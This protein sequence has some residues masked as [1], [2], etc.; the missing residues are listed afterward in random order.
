MKKFALTLMMT[1]CASTPQGTDKPTTS[2]QTLRYEVAGVSVVHIA[3]HS[4]PTVKMT[5]QFAEGADS[6]APAEH[7][8]SSLLASLM[9]RGAAG[10]TAM[11]SAEAVDRLG[12]SIAG[13]ASR[14]SMRFSV[15]GLSRDTT[16]LSAMLA[17]TVRQPNL[18]P[19]EFARLQRQALAGMKSARSRGRN[20]AQKALQQL[21]YGNDRLGTPVGG[22]ESSV[23]KL[24]TEALKTVYQRVIH[25]GHLTIGIF[26][27]VD[28]TQIKPI[29]AEQLKDWKAL[30]SHSKIA[31]AAVKPA[32]RIHLV[33]KPDLTQVNIHLGHA[34]VARSRTDY[35][36]IT[37]MNY[38]LGGGGFSSRLMKL[39]R[40][41]HGLTYG[42]YSNFSAGERAGPFMVTSFTRVDKVRQLIDLT[43]QVMDGVVG[44]GITAE[45]LK[46]AKGYYLGS[47]PLSLETVEGEGGRLLYAARYGLGDD[48]ITAYPKRLAAVTLEQVNKLAKT[49][50]NKDDLVVVLAGPK[51][52]LL[53][54]IKDLGAVRATWWE[55]DRPMPLKQ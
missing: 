33:D 40:S 25:P 50:L 48:Y 49:L 18:D 39:I 19:K 20:L 26:G 34:G 11:E 44:E 28:P 3:D 9:T 51:D 32:V 13:S 38:A 31:E 35:E 5:W 23:A 7:G 29:L 6:E 47:Y 8:A 41:K 22:T 14:D 2:R 17:D 10:K 30:K 21:M 54:A 12:A 4:L 46:D 55:D 45:E 52:K 43:F 15:S 16:A 42:I 27:A 36:A 53:D 24:T 1:A 37:L